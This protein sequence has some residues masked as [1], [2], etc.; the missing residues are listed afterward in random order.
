MA[1]FRVRGLEIRLVSRRRAGS[2]GVNFRCTCLLEVPVVHFIATIELDILFK[3]QLHSHFY[4]CIVYDQEF[5]L[6]LE[7]EH[8]SQKVQLKLLASND[9]PLL[10]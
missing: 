10:S 4:H 8:S 3:R 9:T 1:Y 2:W 7:S 6:G 5:E